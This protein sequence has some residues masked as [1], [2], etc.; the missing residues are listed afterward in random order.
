MVSGEAP[1]R[2]APDRADGETPIRA[3]RRLDDLP[4]HHP[5]AAVMAPPLTAP[6][7]LTLG[8]AAKLMLA[9]KIGSVVVTEDGRDL[10]IVTEHDVVKALA[11]RPAE[12]AALPLRA[13]MSAPVETLPADALIY[14]AVGRMGRR[15]IRHVGVTDETGRIAGVVS[16]RLILRRRGEGGLAIDDA[17]EQA[18]DGPALA[19]A[20]AGVP[21]L[22]RRL[23][24]DG[25][26]AVEVA[27]LSSGIL[28]Q[29]TARA[30]GIAAAEVTA[31][32]GP[33]PGPWCVL[34]L[35]SGGRGESLLA[36]DQDNAV[37]HEGADDGWH[38]ALG[39]RMSIILDRAGIPFCKGG[40]M[41]ARPAWRGTPEGWRARIAHWLAHPRGEALLDT[42]IFFDFRAVHG[43][44]ALAAGLRRDA[45]AAAKG[46]RLFLRLLAERVAG[47]GTALTAFGRFR[48]EGGRADL[49]A[50]GLLPLIG[51]AR[52][53][54]LAQGIEATGTDERLA[55]AAARGH[56]PG[57]DRDRLIAARAVIME[58]ILRQQ[59]ADIAADQPPGSRVDPQILSRGA[60]AKLK[61]ALAD[62]AFAAEMLRG[63]LDVA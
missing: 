39:E 1:D 8:E 16:A 48:L 60:R 9:R 61:Q 51:A 35:G 42:D 31:A 20:W 38:A 52:T 53:M 3:E 28:C 12:A 36:P 63:A 43:D 45:L 49:K 19:A 44:L 62:A 29:V 37:I 7:G 14:R 54:A 55:A 18:G 59:L 13:V 57:E 32:R 58:A 50:G 25:L 5:L 33:A 41:A 24:D 47:T 40:V 34:V 11:E 26:A 2:E 6:P 21:A 27:R 56:L 17:V 4:Y 22:A 30:A 15:G 46:A 23:L 10:G